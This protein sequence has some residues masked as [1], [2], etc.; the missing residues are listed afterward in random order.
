MLM[1]AR[2]FPAWM[3]AQRRHAWE[4]V[5]GDSAPGDL[6]G[7]SLLLVG[8]GEIG[9]VMAR[10]A[11]ALGMHVI[12]VRRSPRQPE[13]PVNEM[14]PPE[15]LDQ[16][17]PRAQWLALACP[18]TDATRRM[19]DAVRLARLPSGAHVINV[20]RGEIIDEQ[21]LTAALASGSLGGAYLDVFE[22][23][24]LP[25]DSPLWDLPNVLLSPHNASASR[26]NDARATEIFLEN[27]GLRARGE[28]MKNEVT[29]T[30]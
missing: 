23:E 16:L 7:Q 2:G 30:R 12:G 3:D 14:H 26:G 25:A 11:Q 19:I 18:L 15:A 17:L 22:H 29:R 27:L 20:A 9:K 21:A 10:I 4:P 8:V 1:L 28:P 5:R 24:P 13:D 6:R